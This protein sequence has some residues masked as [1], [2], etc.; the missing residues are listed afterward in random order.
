MTTMTPPEADT[1]WT[2]ID[3]QRRRTADLLEGLSGEQ[4]DQ[5]SLCE[6]WTVRHVAAH[7]T[8]QRQGLGAALGLVGRNPRLLR[9]VSLNRMIHDSALLT[10]EQLTTDE[11]VSKIREGVGSR[12]HNVG[13]TPL[14]TLT[15]IL[16]HSQDIARPLGIELSMDPAAATVG[17]TR[18]WET[19]RTWM[20]SVFEQLPFDG[21]RLTA[22][23]VD[24][25]RGEGAEVRA[26]VAEILLLLTGRLAAA[27]NVTGEGAP[28]LSR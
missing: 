17:A 12:R 20:S 2:A 7:L 26:P 23:D 27:R 10:A 15:D 22:T 5:P 19:R 11:I 13:V 4:W 8:L 3:D 24:W 9:S 21:V 16:V 25:T 18:R 14:E 28:L 1:L 6:G